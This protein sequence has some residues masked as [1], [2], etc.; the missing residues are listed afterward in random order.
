MKKS[1]SLLLISLMA[2]LATACGPSRSFMEAHSRA[3]IQAVEGI[4][5]EFAT[6]SHQTTTTET[7]L[8]QDQEVETQ[9]TEFDTTLP[10]DSVTGLAPVKRVT[11]QRRRQVARTAQTVQSDATVAATATEERQTIV[12]A[13]TTTDVETTS[14]RGLNTLQGVLCLVGLGAIVV[15]LIWLVRAIRRI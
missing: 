4:R 13:D 15:G 7:I 8:D 14:R 12:Q 3:V 6:Q 11:T 5:F 1:F 10:V 9:T 2:V